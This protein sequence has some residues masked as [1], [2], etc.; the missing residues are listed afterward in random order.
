MNLAIWMACKLHRI[1]DIGYI[2]V[3]L[4]PITNGTNIYP[5]LYIYIYVTYQAN[6]LSTTV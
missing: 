2:F 4:E 3:I 5:Y 6:L 1:D